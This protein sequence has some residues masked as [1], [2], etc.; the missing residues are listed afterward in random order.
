MNKN[1][2]KMR[3]VGAPC[4][5]GKTYAV[6]LSISEAAKAGTLNNTLIVSPSKDLV[7]QTEKQLHDFGVEPEVITTDTTRNVSATAVELFKDSDRYGQVVLMT[8]QGFQRTPVFL[9]KQYWDLYVDEIPSVDNFYDP[10][11]P[12]NHQLLTDFIEITPLN[13]IVN[14]VLIKEGMKQTVDNFLRQSNDEV[15]NIVKPV[16]RDLTEGRK[17]Y[18]D[19]K[20]YGKIVEKQEISKDTPEDSQYGNAKNK[21]YFLSLLTP[22]IFDGWGDVTLLGANFEHSMLARYWHEHHDIDFIPAEDIYARLRYEKHDIGHRL[23]VRYIQ[24]DAWS[25]YQRDMKPC[26]EINFKS[27]GSAIDDYIENV[28][29]KDERYIYVANNDYENKNLKNA[30][31]MPVI[32][33]GLNTYQD[34]TNVYYSPAINRK[35]K[36]MLMLDAIGFDNTF[37]QRATAHEVVYQAIMRCALRNPD[38]DSCSGIV[39]LAT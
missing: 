12:Y 24:E 34:H 26:A 36:H 17:V 39:N 19:T 25:K 8:H 4:G 29:L 16:I 2:K 28:V 30:E 6:C 21:L 13:G 7:R 37:V 23:S 14:E 10:M 35:P 38:I 20:A 32:S 22:A 1:N 3:F 9:K 27:Y 33:H 15:F 5:S 31:R 11:I 18:T